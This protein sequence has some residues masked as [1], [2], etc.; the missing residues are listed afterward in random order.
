MLHQITVLEA[1][2]LGV[3]QGFTEWLPISSSGH[4]VI[5]QALLGISVPPDFDILIMAGTIAALIL[6]FRKKI[7]SLFTGILAGDQSAIKYVAPARP[8]AAARH[9][10][11]ESRDR[12]PALIHS[13][14]SPL[15]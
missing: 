9:R 1:L 5:F 14:R 12:S 4:L 2:F 13:V 8:E 6:Y 11:D 3:L 15:L 10:P 7:Y